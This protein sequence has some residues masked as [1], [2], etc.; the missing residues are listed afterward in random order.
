[1]S[2]CGNGWQFRVGA[3]GDFIAMCRG[4]GETYR[5]CLCMVDHIQGRVSFYDFRKEQLAAGITGEMAW[6]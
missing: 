1:M 4:T 6:A 2:I 3:R 5:D